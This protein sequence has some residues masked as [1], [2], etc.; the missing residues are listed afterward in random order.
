[1]GSIRFFRFG[2]DTIIE[3][4]LFLGFVGILSRV[5]VQRLIGSTNIVMMVIN[6]PNNFSVVDGLGHFDDVGRLLRNIVN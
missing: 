1:M 5:F 6:K 4:L 3:I 2:S